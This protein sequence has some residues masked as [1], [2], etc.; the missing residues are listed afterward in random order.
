MITSLVKYRVN[1]ALK[2]INYR[3]NAMH[4]V[5]NDK[6]NR[7]KN[8]TVF[9]MFFVL[10]LVMGGIGG[11]ITATSVD[12]WYQ[13]LQKP[14]FNPPDWLFAPVWTTL[15]I[16]MAVAAWLVWRRVGFIEGWKPLGVF[17]LQLGLNLVWSFLFFGLQ[18]MDLALLEIIVLLAV[19]IYN[20]LIF[21]RVDRW[22]GLLF[23]P[24]AL[25]VGFAS[26]LNFSLVLLNTG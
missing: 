12:S 14:D 11:A 6:T 13:T 18:R 10:C 22:A 20:G 8:V 21:W 7:I 15:Y 17:L 2:S 1:Q 25:W 5:L 9:I 24:Y 26:V 4:T 16:M 23:I 3:E 19:I